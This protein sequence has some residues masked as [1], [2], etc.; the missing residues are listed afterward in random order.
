[1][2]LKE[3]EIGGHLAYMYIYIGEKRN[4]YRVLVGKY[5]AKRHFRDLVP[6]KIILERM[7]WKYKRVGWIGLT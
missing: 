5:E 2:L 6:H 4:A 7:L 3:D 1:L